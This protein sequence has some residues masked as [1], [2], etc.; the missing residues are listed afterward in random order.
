M[1]LHLT[2][3]CTLFLYLGYAYSCIKTW[4]LLVLVLGL[5]KLSIS[6]MFYRVRASTI[7]PVLLVTGFF[8]FFSFLVVVSHLVEH[9]FSSL[10]PPI[11]RSCQMLPLSVLKII[12]YKCSMFDHIFII[13]KIFFSKGIADSQLSTYNC[14]YWSVFKFE[15]SRRS[16]YRGIQNHIFYIMHCVNICARRRSKPNILRHSKF[17]VT[18]RYAHQSARRRSTVNVLFHGKFLVGY[19]RIYPLILVL[20]QV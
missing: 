8:P 7:K 14:C 17:F 12:A 5:Q 6:C 19:R 18:T 4:L 15:P 2:G 16:A 20:F 3:S 11:L 1:V 13:A 9:F 10:I